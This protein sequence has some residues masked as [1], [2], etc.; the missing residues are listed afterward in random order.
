MFAKN[1]QLLSYNR[2]FFHT[3]HPLINFDPFSIFL[4]GF[5]PL[6]ADNTDLYHKAT[7]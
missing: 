4:C 1:R 3:L 6:Y 2:L 7:R 5:L